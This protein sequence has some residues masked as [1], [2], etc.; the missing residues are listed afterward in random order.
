MKNRLWMMVSGVLLCA[1]TAMAA[2]PPAA[3]PWVQGLVKKID[4]AAEKITL[5]HGPVENLKM[6]P[7]VMPYHVKNV[8]ELKTLHV[9]DK[10]R[11]TVEKLKTGYTV[12]H[13]EVVK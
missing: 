13:I 8:G 3:M 12:L 9:G 2:T 11:F 10:V 7:M 6:P 5:D 1:S 4:L